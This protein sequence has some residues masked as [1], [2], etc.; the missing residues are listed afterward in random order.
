[1]RTDFK[2]HETLNATWILASLSNVYTNHMLHSLHPLKT[3]RVTPYP[4]FSGWLNAWNHR[5]T[6]NL[7]FVSSKNLKQCVV[8]DTTCKDKKPADSQILSSHMTMRGIS[9]TRFFF[10]FLT[11]SW[12]F[13]IHLK[14]PELWPFVTGSTPEIWYYLRNFNINYSTCL[15]LTQ[16]KR[17][18]HFSSRDWTKKNK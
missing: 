2:L 16:P 11:N 9:Q 13:L 15:K 10:F 7:T 12:Y 1:M 17:P 4:T 18:R 6:P 5:R 3:I 8:Y 14:T